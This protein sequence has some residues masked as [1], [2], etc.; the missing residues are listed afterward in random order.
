LAAQPGKRFVSDCTEEFG[1]YRDTTRV[2]A[3]LRQVIQLNARI[4]RFVG[5]EHTFDLDDDKEI[6]PDLSADYDEDR[7]G[8]L[9]EIKARISAASARNELLGLKRYFVAR[10]SW[11][12]KSKVEHNDII[13]VCHVDDANVV[14]AALEDLLKTP[15]NGFLEENGVAV[16]AWSL[17]IPKG[18]DVDADPEL[19][20]EKIHGRTK[21]TAI[22]KMVGKAGG[23]LV[24][25]EV[26]A[27]LRSAYLFTKE[28]AP[29]Q[30][31]MA[32]LLMH[33]LTSFQ[34]STHR[35][36]E[37]RL[38][39]DMTDDI[40]ERAK[41]FF[42]GWRDASSDTVQSRKKW[43]RE[44]LDLIVRTRFRVT[45]PLPHTHKR[46]EE[47]ICSKLERLR[48]KDGSYGR[49]VR[50]LRVKPNGKSQLLPF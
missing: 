39:Q 45:L 12:G 27:S 1:R 48:K 36:T 29:V 43:I 50:N 46:V 35:S 40:Y 24:P 22:E 5:I 21:N 23:I 41:N 13:M 11:D 25:P 26:F 9:F 14:H 34:D 3:A 49:P 20:F 33:V 31:T 47:I 18:G 8:L 19:R 44:A 7:A 28:K 4:G 15:D 38:S 16:W 42:P 10:Q 37:V 17:C 32:F 2:L 6:T 30:Y